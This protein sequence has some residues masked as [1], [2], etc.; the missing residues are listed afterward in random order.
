MAD[1]NPDKGI[2]KYICGKLGHSNKAV[3]AVVAIATCKGILRPYFT[4]KDKHQDPESKKYAA[5]REG[6][7]EGIAIPTYIISSTLAEKLS[8]K[9]L[10]ITSEQFG[11]KLKN[12]TPELRE[13]FD[14]LL[15]KDMCCCLVDP[16]QSKVALFNEYKKARTILQETTG[17]VAVC[18]AALIIIPATCNIV[19]P[20]IMKAFE[21][22]QSGKKSAVNQT[23]TVHEKPVIQ[24][25]VS[26]FEN[27][28]AINN[29]M[30]VYLMSK[31]SASMRIGN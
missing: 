3:Y 17:F 2:I 12:L 11:D 31:N 9:L 14:P 27:K 18:A 28:P 16:D 24:Q 1:K 8:P 10:D 5:F 7:T 19:L 4:M 22:W 13:K 23:P 21:K 29:P 20:P 25:N 6:V 15:K 26:Q 30:H